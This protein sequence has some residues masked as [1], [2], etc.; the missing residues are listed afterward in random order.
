MPDGATPHLL[1]RQRAAAPAPTRPRT[2]PRRTP[3]MERS[4]LARAGD[5]AMA[6]GLEVLGALLGAL[7]AVLAMLLGLIALA[8]RILSAVTTKERQS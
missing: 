1:E 6:A 2:A 3:R 8:H 4:L 5:M 7:V